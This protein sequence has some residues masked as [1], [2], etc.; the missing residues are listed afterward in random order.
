VWVDENG[1]PLSRIS[2]K[3]QTGLER[4]LRAY[5]DGS[6]FSVGIE[7]KG[8][9]GSHIFTAEKKGG[10]ILFYD[11]QNGTMD[12]SEYFKHGQNIS[13]SRIDNAQFNPNINISDVVET[14]MP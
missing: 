8:R 4:A 12:A 7:W 6:R 10:K 1:Q 2:V 9:R 13:Y 14:K 3:G 11:P 5:P